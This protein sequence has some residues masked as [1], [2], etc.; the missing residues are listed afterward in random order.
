MSELL[1]NKFITFDFVKYRE[2]F[3]LLQDDGWDPI[4]QSGS[5]VVMRHPKKP[6]QLTVPNHGSKEVKQGY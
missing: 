5:H 2:L 3:K 1:G 4:R 6:E